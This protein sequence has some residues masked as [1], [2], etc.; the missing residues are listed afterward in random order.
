MIRQATHEDLDQL[1][2]LARKFHAISPFA[3]YTFSPSGTKNYLTSVLSGRPDTVIFMTDTA[4]IGG[5][6]TYLPFCDATIARESFWFSDG[7][8]DGL[9]V[10]REYMRWVESRGVNIDIMTGM[11]CDNHDLQR[12]LNVLDRLGYRG[13]EMTLNRYL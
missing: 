8:S 9:K 3:R 1:V 2:E 5:R 13:A 12:V 10:L 7:G 4:A 6:V 11:N